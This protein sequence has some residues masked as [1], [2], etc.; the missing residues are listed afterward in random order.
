MFSELK[1]N[2]IKRLANGSS[3]EWVHTNVLVSFF[4]QKTICFSWEAAASIELLR[5]DNFAVWCLCCVVMS[6]VVESYLH[7]CTTAAHDAALHREAH[8]HRDSERC[9]R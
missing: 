8:G 7:V 3:H 4:I 6:N 5:F 9:F 1:S 2:V